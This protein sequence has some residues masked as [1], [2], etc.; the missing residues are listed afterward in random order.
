MHF[1]CVWSSTGHCLSRKSELM[2][3]SLILQS[4]VLLW[5][6]TQW[7]CSESK[8]TPK[9][10]ELKSN[11]KDSSGPKSRGGNLVLKRNSV[12]SVATRRDL[13]EQKQKKRVS[14]APLADSGDAD[15]IKELSKDQGDAGSRGASRFAFATHYDSDS[16]DEQGDLLEE[17]VD[18]FEGDISD[19][20][21]SVEFLE[22]IIEGENSN[23][24]PDRII[25]LLLSEPKIGP[26]DIQIKQECLKDFDSIMKRSEEPV[27][28][29][30]NPVPYDAQDDQPH[31]R[32]I[33]ISFRLEKLF[34]LKV[35]MVIALISAG[36]K[37]DRGR[38]TNG[39][40]IFATLETSLKEKLKEI[41]QKI[42]VGSNLHNFAKNALQNLE[43]KWNSLSNA[44]KQSKLSNDQ[45]LA[46][47]RAF[48]DALTAIDVASTSG[49]NTES[50]IREEIVKFRQKLTSLRPEV[51]E[52]DIAEMSKRLGYV[53][54][55]DYMIPAIR[56]GLE[57]DVST[58]P[59]QIERIKKEN[60][61]Y[62]RLI[63]KVDDSQWSFKFKL[64]MAKA[65]VPSLI[66]LATIASEHPNAALECQNARFEI[67]KALNTR[68]AQI[69][70]SYAD[71]TNN[72]EAQNYTEQLKQA[73]ELTNK[74]MMK[75]GWADIRRET[76][77]ELKKDIEEKQNELFGIL[78]I[79]PSLKELVAGTLK[80]LERQKTF[81]GDISSEI[82]K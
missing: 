68:F 1:F 34:E 56:D 23:D 8:K 26:S 70:G 64:Q 16:N 41:D 9:K 50:P 11:K 60:L 19:D 44:V 15:S 4:L 63:H 75:P 80:Q 54:A 55:E 20:E 32:A 25:D 12:E 51:E 74:N 43:S 39:Q 72:N 22:Q 14:F 29:A 35:G 46:E 28:S 36:E 69:D 10:E 65:V 38:F 66:L 48:Q 3:V 2:N 42:P 17:S 78:L 53:H 33:S 13:V 5:G 40:A 21:Q 27:A 58:L 24:S 67:M 73:V 59:A 79:D 82:K 7:G 6:F 76:L 61:L 62:L 49:G 81:L 37:L 31:Y 57:Q 30:I 71:F 52:A 47:M 77:N 45:V 18:E